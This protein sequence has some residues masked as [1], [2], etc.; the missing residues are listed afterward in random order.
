MV[1][2]MFKTCKGC[3]NKIT[4]RLCFVDFPV[5]Y[6]RCLVTL[7]AAYNLRRGIL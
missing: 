7:Y 6:Q 2:G 4:N 1:C 5:R 3:F